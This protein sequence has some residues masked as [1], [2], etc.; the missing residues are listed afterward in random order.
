VS[1]EIAPQDVVGML[2]GGGRVALVDVR[3]EAAYSREHLLLAATMPLARLEVMLPSRVPQRG[4]ALVFCDADGKGEAPQALARARKWGYTDIRVLA[5]GNAGWKAAGLPLYSGMNVPS[6]AF[7]EAVEVRLHTPKISVDALYD[8]RQRKVPHVLIDCRPTEEYL[9]QSLPGSIS[10]PGVELAYRFAQVV[11]DPKMQV[12]VHCAGR[13]RSIMGA[14]T[15][16]ESGVPNPV[17]SL[18]N[19]TMGWLLAGHEAAAGSEVPPTDSALDTTPQVRSYA[20]DISRKHGIARI[21]EK[22]AQA[23]LGDAGE[24]V[25][26]LLDVR[27]PAEYEGGHLPGAI[28]APGG[29][30]V[31]ATD[32]YLA[33]RNARVILTDDNGIRATIAAGWL[34]RMGWPE[35]HV[36]AM[37]DCAGALVP[38]P[39]PKPY[40]F[41]PGTRTHWIDA[42][43]LGALLAADTA[44]VFDLD[45]SIEYEAGHVRGA[46]F[47]KR[48]SLA[49]AVSALG[50][51]RHVVLTSADGVAAR[52][53]AADLDGRRPVWVLQGGKAAARGAGIPFATGQEVMLDPPDEMWRRPVEAPGDRTAHMQNYLKWEIGLIEQIDRDSTV[54]FLV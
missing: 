33:V 22:R 27:S 26:M 49:K 42:A 36:L 8:L 11:K 39:E 10:L 23:L 37:Q 20:E 1:V 19:G 2:Q 25:T 29:Q 31:Q 7:G 13:T 46:R 15:L 17:C 4:C 14:Q 48:G 35:V 41:A 43:G 3:E 12:V 54:R 32:K 45:N 53:A 28:H 16:I 30:L 44:D 24:H 21:D 18:E 40:Y 47:V 51:E 38:G 50:G 34:K 52:I 9:K 5:G 6:K